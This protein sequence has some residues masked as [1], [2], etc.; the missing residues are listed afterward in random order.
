MC[1]ESLNRVTLHTDL[2]VNE[3]DSSGKYL[4]L[5]EGRADL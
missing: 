5:T 3:R 4:G 2:C 1:A